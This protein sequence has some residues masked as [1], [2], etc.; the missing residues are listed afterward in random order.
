MVN[1]WIML[2]V[3]VLVIAAMGTTLFFFFR[4]LRRI[5]VQTWGGRADTQGIR[6]AMRR[7]KQKNEALGVK[8]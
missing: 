2:V 4:R 5:E 8:R 6:A 1:V 7:Y 3:S